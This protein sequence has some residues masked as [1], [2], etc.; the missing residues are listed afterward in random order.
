MN[1]PKRTRQS[2][3]ARVPVGAYHF[4]LSQAR[5]HAAVA[6]DIAAKPLAEDDPG[7]I[8]AFLV[9]V[10]LAIELYLKTFMVA[11]RNGQ[12]STGHDL[13]SLLDEFP[14]RFREAFRSAYASI[15]TPPNA[16]I[17]GRS[18]R[19]SDGA[20]PP[21]PFPQRLSYKTFDETV[22]ALSSAF[23][24]ARY[25]Y[26]NMSKDWLVLIYPTGPAL[27]VIAAIEKVFQQ[28]SSGHFE[29]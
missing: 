9:N 6:R 19:F 7:Q 12:V 28:Y 29:T 15:E 23:V 8:L 3:T 11:G 27:A 1:T 17:V 24:S 20:Q 18:F 26:E 10:S 4:A 13:N 22:M 2:K 5:A 14:E 16:T 25:M 21:S